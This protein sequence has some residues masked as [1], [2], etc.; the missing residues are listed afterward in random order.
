MRRKSKQTPDKLDKP[1]LSLNNALLCTII[2]CVVLFY[3]DLKSMIFLLDDPAAVY[4][5]RDGR[6]SVSV[7]AGRGSSS[8]R[9]DKGVPSELRLQQDRRPIILQSEGATVETCDDPLWCHIEM[10]RKSYFKFDPPTDSLRWKRA[11]VRYLVCL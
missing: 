8:V 7:G 10:P 6:D 9:G 3:E 11:Q 2:L 4:S 1:Y 5:G